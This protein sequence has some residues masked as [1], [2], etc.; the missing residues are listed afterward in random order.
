MSKSKVPNMVDTQSEGET[1]SDETFNQMGHTLIVC[2]KN[3]IHEWNQ[4]IQNNM[5]LN[6]LNIYVHYGR[7]RN[8]ELFEY[9]LML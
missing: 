3:S 1:D 6:T 5:L 8:M 9:I 2:S 4:C 7:H